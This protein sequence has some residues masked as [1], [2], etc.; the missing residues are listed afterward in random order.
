[1]DN[2]II[3][4][5]RKTLVPGGTSPIVRLSL[6]NSS[7]FDAE[8][9]R[10]CIDELERIPVMVAMGER[11]SPLQKLALCVLKDSAGVE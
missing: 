3:E 4:T 9:I 11:V 1:M 8:F 7:Y 2:D 6:K 5:M 10:S